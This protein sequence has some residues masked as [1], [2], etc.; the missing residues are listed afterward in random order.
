MADQNPELEVP[1]VT[2]V[3]AAAS[4]AAEVSSA[5]AVEAESEAAWHSGKRLGQLSAQWHAH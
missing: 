5:E 4:A 1:M 2:V 3:V